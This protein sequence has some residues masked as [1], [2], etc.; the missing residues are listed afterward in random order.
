MAAVAASALG[1]VV[2]AGASGAAE[3]EVDK[4]YPGTAVARMR[5]ARARA[6][7]ANLNGDWE[8]VRRQVLL[9]GGLRDLPNARPGSGYTGH[10]FNDWNH[11]DLTAM[12]GE[13]SANTNNG[14]VKG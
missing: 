14:Q 1:T 7:A 2:T 3:D 4:A 8:S 12:L 5:A 6:T 9:A 11:C 13:V 10:S